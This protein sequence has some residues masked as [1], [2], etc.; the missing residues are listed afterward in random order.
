MRDR[1]SC[2]ESY[3]TRLKL[4]K[5][6][7]V[8]GD[9]ILCVLTAPDGHEI[10]SKIFPDNAHRELYNH[11]GITIDSVTVQRVVNTKK[12][13]IN[14]M[15]VKLIDAGRVLEFITDSDDMA[16]KVYRTLERE[17]S[18]LGNPIISYETMKCGKQR[19][20]IKTSL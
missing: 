7:E 10:T 17:L 11:A 16:G 8:F 1:F 12:T 2:K 13:K 6:Y 14:E 18:V 4:Q 20:S 19:C 5:P 3:I 15:N 9:S